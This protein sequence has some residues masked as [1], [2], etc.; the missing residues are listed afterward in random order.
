VS[1]FFSSKRTRQ[2][3][4][5]SERHSVRETDGFDKLLI[6]MGEIL[7][8][9]LVTAEQEHLAKQAISKGAQDYLLSGHLDA[10]TLSRAINNAIER[11]VV[12]D[13]LYI[14]KERA[15]VTLNSIGDAVMCTDVLGKVT[16]LNVVAENMTRWSRQEAASQ[17]VATVLR[18]IDGTT[19]AVARDPMELAVRQDKTVGLTADCVLIRRDGIEFAIEDS[20]APIHDR[21]GRVTGAVI[22]FHDVSTA[23]AM[24]TKMAHS[25]QHDVV[26]NLPNRLLL[27]DRITLSISM[28]RRQNRHVAV[29]FLD[30]DR[31]KYIDD[32]L[33]HAVG[34]QL[35][36]SV[37]K[38]LVGGLRDSDT[39]SRQG[40]DE[41]IILLPDISSEIDAAIAARKI[42]K[43]LGEAHSIETQNLHID[44]S[45]GISIFPKDG[46]DAEALIKNADTAM[47]H[48][49]ENGRNNYQFFT[50]DMSLRAMERQSLEGDLRGA[51]A[52]REIL[53]HYQPKVNLETGQIT[54]VEALVR[55][56]HPRR[57]LSSPAQFI[58]IAE[59]CGVIVP[60]G[61]WVLGEA[62]RQTRRW[63][64][65]GL[66]ILPIAVN[67][68]ALEVRMDGF[69]EGIRSIL[70]ETEM[71]ARYVELE[72]TEGVLMQ[73]ADQALSVFRALKLMGVRLA[74]DDFG[75][76]Y[77]SLSYLRQF[78]ISVLK[79]DRSFVHQ[80]SSNPEDSRIISAI[81][82]MGRS[83]GYNVVAEGVET[84]EQRTYLQGEHCGEGQGYLFSRPLSASR[85][86]A[87]RSTGEA[88]ALVH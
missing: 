62:C 66:P 24:S 5:P 46:E 54:G 79:I 12:D 69:V 4:R 7:I 45:I 83:L 87:F 41:F 72:L 6:A 31:F 51:L 19:R 9:V 84:M 67:V 77:S 75:T 22:V 11:K 49:K 57:G 21:N 26:T 63:V 71:D 37:S 55:W 35:L 50:N 56:Q 42:L 20:A 70:A 1:T 2:S 80:I 59:D 15:M 33:G 64:R 39:V 29:L 65:A 76:G 18:I 27:N 74:V 85:M 3:E 28:A 78:P 36:Q 32:S 73:D 47:Y 13:A 17:P 53:L 60:L 52:R 68:S 16:Y 23:R 38:R 14:E 86:A 88:V 81:I 25:A 8:M 82:G 58:P 10:C 30:L 44:G 61:R 43:L 40:G 48:A 34:D